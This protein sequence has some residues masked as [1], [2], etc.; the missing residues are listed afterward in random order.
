MQTIIVPHLN[1][2][3][4]ARAEERLEET[5]AALC[6]AALGRGDLVSTTLA[7]RNAFDSNLALYDLRSAPE[8]V[9]R[10]VSFMRRDFHD[11]KVV[12]A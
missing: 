3:Q 12:T 8:I 7:Y 11:G 10:K 5:R 4:E 2:I 1:Y 9:G 6:M